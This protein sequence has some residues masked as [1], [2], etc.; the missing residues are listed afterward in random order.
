MN[1][2]LNVTLRKGWKGKERKGRKGREGREGRERKGREL[3][4]VEEA[5]DILSY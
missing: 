3:S 1:G 2:Y 4:R 5:K